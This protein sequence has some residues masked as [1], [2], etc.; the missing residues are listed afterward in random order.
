MAFGTHPHDRQ[1]TSL[2]LESEPLGEGGQGVVTRVHGP[3]PLVYK[4]Y[5]PQAG[6]VNGHALADLVSFGHA[7]PPG[8]RQLLF[9]HCAWPVARVLHG[10]RVTGFLMH[11]V[12]GEFRGT[13]GGKS[14]LVELQYLLYTPNWSWQDLHQPD[15]EG[16]VTI[17]LLAAQLIDLLH[18]HG[19]VLGDISFRN[20]LWRPA[21]PYRIF[22]LDCDGFRRHGGEPVLRQAHTPDWDDPHQPATGPDLDTDRYKLALLMGRL[23]T[24]NA[25]VRPGAEPELL[26][27]LDPYVATAVTGLFAQAATPRG[28]RPTAAEW[29]QAVLG[30]RRI[31]LN[32]PPVR[33]V[34]VPPERADIH[35]PGAK[36]L[37]QPIHSVPKDRLRPV[38]PADD[39]SKTS[40]GEPRVYLPIS[41]PFS[42]PPSPPPMRSRPPIAPPSRPPSPP[43]PPPPMRSLPRPPS[44]PPS[45]P[46]RSLP[47]AASPAPR[48]SSPVAPAPAEPAAPSR[49]L[50]LGER[51]TASDEFAEQRRISPGNIS[52]DKVVLL[53][54]A[55]QARG[56]R[57]A[58][59]EVAALIG[60]PVD[61]TRL[62]M[63]TAK[64]LLNVD[65]YDV[66][67]L[68]DGDQTVDLNL[69]L[70]KEQF[71]D[72]EVE[73]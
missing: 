68:K 69:G 8:D 6:T 52:D 45:P 26:S 64:R 66:L 9:A 20:L 24:R 43:L 50:T 49:P 63:V 42:A 55:L 23:L 33:Q 25:Y 35:L 46:L 37:S 60:E 61:R 72:E 41:L 12:P 4:E 38:T 58:V 44:P 17:A 48:R 18:G 51:V 34:T 56:G 53:L 47:P 14:K 71:L 40:S 57:L 16:R 54:D 70:L 59:T 7:L 10:D 32:R 22:V 28:L 29:A 62:L 65:G 11:E 2:S 15:L 1:R 39:P 27:G 13:I 73:P 3:G 30:R 21:P 67:T 31:L 36:R 5:M 19:F